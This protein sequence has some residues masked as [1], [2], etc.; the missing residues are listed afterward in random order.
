MTHV[1]ETKQN[2]TGNRNCLIEW[3]DVNITGNDFKVSINLFRE[4]KSDLIK[5]VNKNMMAMLVASIKREKF[6]REPNGNLVVK[7]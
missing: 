3:P 1:P 4:L 2:K 6:Q 5:E 7:M